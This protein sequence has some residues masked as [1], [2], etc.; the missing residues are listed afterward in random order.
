[1]R[2]WR[3]REPRNSL[4]TGKGS[5]PKAQAM[6]LWVPGRRS[7]RPVGE[8][9]WGLPVKGFKPK[10]SKIFI[11]QNEFLNAEEA[12]LKHNFRTVHL[13]AMQRT[14]WKEDV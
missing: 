9:G 7:E 1:M 13:A 12:K 6:S 14:G 11:L 2:A 5:R 4:H 8:Q 3:Q 10:A